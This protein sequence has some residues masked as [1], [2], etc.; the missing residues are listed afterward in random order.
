MNALAL[1]M[2]EILRRWDMT[3]SACYVT[4][5]NMTKLSNTSKYRDMIYVAD[6]LSR[7]AIEEVRAVMQE[8][9]NVLYSYV[10]L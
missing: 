1:S 5:K 10:K 6:A 9:K 4:G 8:L 7:G 2:R 3:I